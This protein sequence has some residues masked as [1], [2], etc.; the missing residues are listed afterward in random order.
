MQTKTP[1]LSELAP[2]LPHQDLPQHP[3][4]LDQVPF[5]LKNG[6][7]DLTAKRKDKN[8]CQN[9]WSE[10][11]ES[12]LLTMGAWSFIHDSQTASCLTLLGRQRLRIKLSLEIPNL[13]E[14]KVRIIVTLFQTQN[15]SDF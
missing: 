4:S 2:P 10:T 12:A 13:G 6:H 5:V 8:L 1:S 15:E 3:P 11:V 7:L 14:H 9:Y